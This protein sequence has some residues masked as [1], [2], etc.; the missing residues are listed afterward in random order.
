MRH[1]NLKCIIV[2]HT[3]WDREWYLTSEE[4]RLWFLE[5]FN[6]ILEVLEE[7]PKFHCFLLDGQVVLLEDFLEYY[8]EKRSQIEELVKRGKL[9]IGP[10]YIQPDEFLVSGEALIRNLLKG[11]KLAKS[12]GKCMM[13]GY[14]PDTFGH[15][16]QLPQILSQFNL[17]S[18]V[19]KRGVGDEGEELGS[20]FIWEAPDGSRIIAVHLVAG[21]HNISKLGLPTLAPSIEIWRSPAGWITALHKTYDDE[22][23]VLDLESALEYVKELIEY[24]SRYA[25]TPYLLLM[26][27]SDHTPIQTSIVTIID[28]LREKLPEIEFEHGSL[29][30]YIELIKE[31]RENFKTYKGE[32]RGAR[33]SHLLVGVYSS[34]VYLKQLNYKAQL[35]LEKYAEPLA[36]I[37]KILKLNPDLKVLDYAWKLL[38]KNHFHDSIYGSGTDPVHRENEVRFE[39]VIGIASNYAFR[40]SKEIA[41]LTTPPLEDAEAYVFVF[42]PLNW[43]RGGVVSTYI[44]L[45]SGEYHAVDEEGRIYPVKICEDPNIEIGNLKQMF[46][47]CKEVPSIGYRVLAIKKGK[48]EIE[49]LKAEGNTIENEFYRIEANPERGGILRI[50]DKERGVVL[51]DVN[52]FIDGGDAGDEYNYSPPSGD[53]LVSSDKYKAEVK[54]FLDTCR[55]ILDIKLDFVL[56]ARLTGKWRSIESVSNPLEIQVWLEPGSRL[57]KFKVLF[58]NNSEDHRLRVKIPT[59]KSTD[60]AYADTHFYVIERPH[61][62]AS[63]GEE[64]MEEPPRTHPMISWIDVSDE[65]GGVALFSRGLH[66]YETTVENGQ[67]SILLTLLRAVGWLS[68]SDLKTRKGGAGPDIAVPDA[69]CKRSL[70]FEYALYLHDGDWKEGEVY[71]RAQEY[72]VPLLATSF[73]HSIGKLPSKLSFFSAKPSELLVSALKPAEEGGG[74]VMRFYNITGKTIRGIIEYAFKPEK[75][76]RS[77]MDEE[78]IEEIDLSNGKTEIEVGAH[79]I[80][81]L[82]AEYDE[83]S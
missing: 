53:L 56:P 20:E 74:I 70:V 21:Y 55:A 6:K 19:F 51:E 42:N 31:Y 1:D 64:W 79:K 46:L 41:G 22:E 73:K 38:L 34:R 52:I 44:E 63:T 81:T 29:E 26:N 43:E 24:L 30:D 62:P 13:V 54:S 37:A 28:Y 17:D 78:K 45:P 16:A 48:A 9:A 67:V 69:Q 66:E 65:N 8:P 40:L 80:V 3:H 61:Q 50:M 59:G 7:N 12:Y 36:S 18:I 72:T 47:I 60:T 5:S 23:K 10:W 15:T 33:Y 71:K 57:I 76:F 27:G 83:Q 14:L 82:I 4:F 49:G 2:S 25:R 35:M 75:V 39:K 77:K 11:I 68:R 58:E 32:L